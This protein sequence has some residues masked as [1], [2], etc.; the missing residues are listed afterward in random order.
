MRNSQPS[1]YGYKQS[2]YEGT[3]ERP[4]CPWRE[5]SDYD[6]VLATSYPR[7]DICTGGVIVSDCFSTG[8]AREAVDDRRSMLTDQMRRFRRCVFIRQR[9]RSL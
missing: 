5:V 2:S 3:Q 6:W 4:T 7:I 9:A 1:K 8:I